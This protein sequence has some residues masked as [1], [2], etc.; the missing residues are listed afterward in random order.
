MQEVW[1]WRE[2]AGIAEPR[3]GITKYEI[4]KTASAGKALNTVRK[5]PSHKATGH[6]SHPLIESRAHCGPISKHMSLRSSV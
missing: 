1:Y 6:D 5:V 2:K 3:W 4:V